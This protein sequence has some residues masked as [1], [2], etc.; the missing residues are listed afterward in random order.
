MQSSDIANHAHGQSS[1][2]GQLLRQPT[3]RLSLSQLRVFHDDFMPNYGFP[4]GDS[5]SIESFLEVI[6]NFHVLEEL[7][8]CNRFA[9]ST[10]PNDQARQHTPFFAQRLTSVKIEDFVENIALIMSRLIIPPSADVAL[11][12]DP[13][14]HLGNDR[15]GQY[16]SDFRKMLPRDEFLLPA[17][18][19]YE[20]LEIRSE[21]N[22]CE[23]CVKRPVGPSDLNPGGLS[24]LLWTHHDKDSDAF[25]IEPLIKGLLKAMISGVRAIFPG[26]PITHIE[27]YGP[28]DAVPVDTWV[29]TLV[30]F[31]ALRRLSIDDNKLKNP[32]TAF[33][34]ALMTRSLPDS[35]LLC[36]NLEF[37]ELYGA[38]H[39]ESHLRHIV[40]CLQDRTSRR[41]S[42]LQE[43]MAELHGYRSCVSVGKVSEYRRLFAGFAHK[44]TFKFKAAARRRRE[45]TLG[46]PEWMMLYMHQDEA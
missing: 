34:D 32:H 42:I 18:A 20:H 4:P 8:L 27:V 10:N 44:S 37:L 40:R 25:P 12:G 5:L 2:R 3:N 17:M 22:E 13:G 21:L 15:P 30:Q 39:Y 36:P 31:P 24:L 46:D 33:L 7:S 1:T 28:L 14:R 41:S 43:F 6:P 23:L 35:A 16:L 9:L 11:T 29:S 19:N 45:R 38:A 26:A